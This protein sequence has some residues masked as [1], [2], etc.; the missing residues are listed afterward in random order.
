MGSGPLFDRYYS[1]N[2]R[3][4]VFGNGCVKLEVLIGVLPKLTNVILTT[5]FVTQPFGRRKSV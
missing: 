2:G 4:I 1:I 3:L 5:D